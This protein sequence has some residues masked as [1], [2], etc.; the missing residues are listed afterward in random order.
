M[1]PLYFKKLKSNSITNR[2]HFLKAPES[3][4]SKAVCSHYR[5]QRC[6]GIMFRMDQPINSFHYITLSF[7]SPSVLCIFVIYIFIFNIADSYTCDSRLFVFLSSKKLC[8][9]ALSCYHVI[10]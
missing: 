10:G 7:F 6:D 5:T 4:V 3:Q 8:L 1:T 9:R 2:K